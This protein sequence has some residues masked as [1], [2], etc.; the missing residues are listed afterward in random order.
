MGVFLDVRQ[1][2]TS[3]YFPIAVAMTTRHIRAK[4][5]AM[6]HLAC[7]HHAIY[8]RNGT[9]MFAIGTGNSITT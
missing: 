4:M 8:I 6:K 7:G 5:W 9:Y 1:S 3:H 2:M